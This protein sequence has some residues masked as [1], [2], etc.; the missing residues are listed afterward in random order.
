[1]DAHSDKPKLAE[2]I[3]S[4]LEVAYPTLAREAERV[5]LLQQ[6]RR[7]V[8]RDPARAAELLSRA[9]SLEGADDG[10]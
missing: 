4:N 3:A 8:R 2:E 5:S 7:C 10:R 6:A 1:M 9:K